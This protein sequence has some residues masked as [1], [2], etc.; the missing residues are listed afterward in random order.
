[1][2]AADLVDECCLTI[3]PMMLGARAQ[4]LLPVTIDDPVRWALV[5]AR[6][7]GNHLFTRYRRDRR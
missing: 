6:V 1:L 4:P 5:A 7:A 3:A 2:A